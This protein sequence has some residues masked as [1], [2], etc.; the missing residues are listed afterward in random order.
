[1][2]ELAL[3]SLFIRANLGSI[4][5][6]TLRELSIASPA[7]AQT[8]P[9]APLP[10][11]A[12]VKRQLKINSCSV[13]HPLFLRFPLLS[14]LQDCCPSLFFPW[15]QIGSCL[16]LLPCPRKVTFKV[17]GLLGTGK[18]SSDPLLV[19]MWTAC[20]KAEVCSVWCK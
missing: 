20:Q 13:N 3:L 15:P 8:G 14:L 4:S 10:S 11:V 17:H 18:H 12:A 7:P 1:M 9:P 5:K 16:P 6:T 2:Q 19:Q